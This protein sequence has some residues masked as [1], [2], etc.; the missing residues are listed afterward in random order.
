MNQQIQNIRLPFQNFSLGSFPSQKDSVNSNSGVA[1]QGETIGTGLTMKNTIM[2][3]NTMEVSKGANNMVYPK[4]NVEGLSSRPTGKFNSPT[5][6]TSS[7]TLNNHS[8]FPI[9][10]KQSNPTNE[11][12]KNVDNFNGHSVTTA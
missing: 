9:S 2:N 1:H 11:V 10:S 4:S 6:S 8:F 3:S 7:S 5:I 12:Q